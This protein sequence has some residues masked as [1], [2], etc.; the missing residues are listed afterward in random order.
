MCPPTHK[1]RPVVLMVEHVPCTQHS[2]QLKRIPHSGASRLIRFVNILFGFDFPHFIPF[3]FGYLLCKDDY[4]LFLSP[5]IR[6]G[7]VNSNRTHPTP[8]HPGHL[9]GMNDLPRL[10]FTVQ[11]QT[12]RDLGPRLG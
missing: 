9:S 7:T 5:C 11:R 6:N 2:V 1:K 4:I 3:L 10:S 12:E 8:H